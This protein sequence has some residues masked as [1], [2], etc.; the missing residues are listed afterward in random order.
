[1][2]VSSASSI[3][4]HQCLKGLL[5]LTIDNAE[6]HLL[7]RINLQLQQQPVVENETGTGL[8]LISM[9]KLAI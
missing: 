7:L 2:V 4:K 3:P 8:V 1:M 5:T 6:F 9:S